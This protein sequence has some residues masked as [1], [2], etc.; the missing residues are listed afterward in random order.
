MMD[1]NLTV[2]TD[3]TVSDVKALQFTR[4]AFNLAVCLPTLLCPIQVLD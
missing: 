3:L 1:S 4:R 2:K